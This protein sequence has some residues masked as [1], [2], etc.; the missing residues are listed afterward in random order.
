[1]PKEQIRITSN[2]L[3]SLKNVLDRDNFLRYLCSFNPRCL[4]PG[5]PMHVLRN[6]QKFDDATYGL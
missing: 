5:T 4:F 6:V 3:Y 1:M 2:F